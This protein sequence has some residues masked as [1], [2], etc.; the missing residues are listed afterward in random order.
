MTGKREKNWA[1]EPDVINEIQT[2]G[3]DIWVKSD[4]EYSFILAPDGRKGITAY[5][6][7]KANLKVGYTDMSLVCK[8]GNIRCESTFLNNSNI[9]KYAKVF[10]LSG[11]LKWR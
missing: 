7:E 4:P 5:N 1:S 8:P 3:D 2:L 11:R 6:L 10:D 9:S